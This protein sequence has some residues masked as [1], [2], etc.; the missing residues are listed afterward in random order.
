MRGGASLRSEGD[1]GGVQRP[2]P[3][4]LCRAPGIERLRWEA[5]ARKL[6]CWVAG[7]EVRAGPS[8]EV[9]MCRGSGAAGGSA[10]TLTAPEV[11]SCS[12]RRG[13]SV[14]A[15]LAGRPRPCASPGRAGGAPGGRGGGC[16]MEENCTQS[17]CFAQRLQLFLRVP[18]WPL[19][20]FHPGPSYPSSLTL[21]SG[22]CTVL[23]PVTRQTPFI[24]SRATKGSRCV[25]GPG[26]FLV[27]GD[28]VDHCLSETLTLVCGPPPS[29]GFFFSALKRD[30]FSI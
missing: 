18:P 5:E 3:P 27:L 25:S 10:V 6:E 2:G 23:P 19:L 14:G 13:L 15:Q 21:S 12:V 9:P 16:V 30:L 1:R 4:D 22:G 8:G 7:H 28:T 26:E 11:S 17:C 24:W 29:H 20:S